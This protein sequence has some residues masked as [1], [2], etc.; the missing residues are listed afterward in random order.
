MTFL[1]IAVDFSKEEW[2]LLDP[3]QRTEYHDVMLE[4]FGHLVSVG[5]AAPT[6]PPH[7]CRTGFRRVL[8]WGCTLF[9]PRAS[10]GHALESL[11]SS[12][13]FTWPVDLEGWPW[14]SGSPRSRAGRTCHLPGDRDLGALGGRPA[15]GRQAPVPHTAAQSPPVVH[16]H[17]WEEI[18]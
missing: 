14:A 13:A 17:T 2:G 12:W 1:D 18:L 7:S 15:P 9:G 6:P 8:S 4:T 10:T 3:S 16:E 5:K 11:A